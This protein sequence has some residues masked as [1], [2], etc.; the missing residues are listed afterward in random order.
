MEL[1][2]EHVQAWL[3]AYLA[4]WKSYEPDEIGALWSEDAIYHRNPS[5]KS[6]RGRDAIVE[7][8]MADAHLDVDARYEGDYRP[9][10]VDG[11][12]AVSYGATRFFESDG[13]PADVYLNVWTMRFDDEGRCTEFHE[14]YTYPP[15]P[16][17][18]EP[19]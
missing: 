11:N 8:W 13:T 17:R 9:I 5:S 7:F 12:V 1:T 14:T 2:Y 3:D 16:D 10:L 15:G 4:A 19:N 18:R 6:A